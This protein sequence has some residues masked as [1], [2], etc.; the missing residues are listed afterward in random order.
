MDYLQRTKKISP[1]VRLKAEQYINLGFQRLMTFQAKDGGFSLWERG[2]P[3][4]FLT[5]FGLMEISDMSRVHEVDPAVVRRAQ[6]WLMRKESGD[7]S[8]PVSPIAHRERASNSGIYAFTAY[9]V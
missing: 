8:W 4:T 9:A 3:E 6:E 1:E 2:E 7:G 5:A